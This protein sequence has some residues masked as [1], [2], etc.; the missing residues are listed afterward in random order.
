[1][2]VT[3]TRLT[4][5]ARESELHALRADVERWQAEMLRKDD[6]IHELEEKVS[7]L[8]TQREAAQ[9]CLWLELC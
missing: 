5:Q 2:K 6:V 1:V 9:A 4:Q 8:G 7:L 3:R